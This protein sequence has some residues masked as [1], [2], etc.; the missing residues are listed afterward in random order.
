MQLTEMID[1]TRSLLNDPKSAAV[2]NGRLLLDVEVIR[3]LNGGYKDFVNK[4]MMCENVVAYP[5]VVNQARYPK[6]MN[7]LLVESIMWE[8]RIEIVCED[9]KEFR[10]RLYMSPTVG[11]AIP[12]IYEEYPGFTSQKEFQFWPITT[13]ADVSTTLTA[14]IGTSDVMIPVVSVHNFPKSGWLI[15]DGE[16]IWYNNIDI[17]ANQFL[18]CER[19]KGMS[20]PASHTGSV[21]WGRITIR[22]T[23]M[24][25][26]LTLMTDEPQFPF[27][28][29]EA[30]CFYAAEEGFI[31]MQKNAEANMM[32]IKYEDFIKRANEIRQSRNMDRPF[33][34]SGFEFANYIY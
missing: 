30:L 33:S 17:V 21:K 1:H 14:P 2:P 3:M 23:F 27:A 18:Q 9:I 8:E 15:L 7:A 4:A 31:K 5:A 34:W 13:A 16:Q 22:Y 26:L 24:P 6:P 25:A 29:H 32:H 19:G 12:M 20:T 10:A 28:W 11:G